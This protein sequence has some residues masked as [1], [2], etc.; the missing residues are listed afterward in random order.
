MSD[1]YSE[2]VAFD[3]MRRYLEAFCEPFGGD[4]ELGYLLGAISS[5]WEDGRPNVLSEWEDYLAVLHTVRREQEASSD[6]RGQCPLS[7]KEAFDSM[8]LFLDRHYARAGP[9]AM[10]R[11]ILDEL[12]SVRLDRFERSGPWSAWLDAVE[13]VQCGSRGS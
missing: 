6:V 10:I 4:E 12:N 13:T 3:A 1:K 8:V 5:V 11:P 7:D 2:N 9:R